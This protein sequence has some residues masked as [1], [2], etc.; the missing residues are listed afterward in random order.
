MAPLVR[1]RPPR[2]RRIKTLALPGD[3]K[4]ILAALIAQA[5]KRDNR[6]N[7]EERN[8][9]LCVNQRLIYRLNTCIAE[10]CPIC[11]GFVWDGQTPLL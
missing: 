3:E 2:G 5:I 10:Y 1:E 6:F 8:T 9:L 11:G 4:D 7:A